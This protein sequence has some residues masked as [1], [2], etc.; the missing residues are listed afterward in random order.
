MQRNI[1]NQATWNHLNAL[2]PFPISELIYSEVILRRRNNF[3]SSNLF[4]FLSNTHY[5]GDTAQE[6]KH[7]RPEPLGTLSHGT[8][9]T[10]LQS[11]GFCSFSSRNGQKLSLICG[12]SNKANDCRYQTPGCVTVRM[13]QGSSQKSRDKRIF[14]NE[15]AHSQKQQWP[16]SL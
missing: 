9:I 2:F 3:S 13:L 7:G 4:L 8:K 5:T 11:R 15:E 12:S 10:F 16:G 1:L 6:L 14:G